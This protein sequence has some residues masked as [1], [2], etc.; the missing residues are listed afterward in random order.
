[1]SSATPHKVTSNSLLEVRHLTKSYTQHNLPAVDGVDLQVAHQEIIALLG[2]SGCGK[3]TLL[4]L[5]AGFETIDRGAILLEGR[6]MAHLP[7]EMR[8]IGMVFQ[9]FALFPHLTCAENVAFGLHKKPPKLR[10]KII[11]EVLELV[12][13]QDFRKRLPHQLSGGQQQ[14]LALARALA[15]DPTLILL[16][17]PLSNLDAQIRWQLRSELR[18]ILKTAGKSAILVTH[19]QEEA[20]HIADRVAV[21][22][23]GKIEQLDT[24]QGI[25]ERPQTAF[26]AEFVCQANN[27][28]AQRGENGW[29]TTIG[30][31]ALETPQDQ[32]EILV[33]P[34]SLQI[35][36]DPKGTT[37]IVDRLFLG[38]EVMYILKTQAQHTLV[39][40]SS[41]AKADLQVGATVAVTADPRQILLFQPSE[42]KPY[43]IRP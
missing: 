12:G 11:Q 39:A 29:E 26:V 23:R 4:R 3:T 43:P 21:M 18:R 10:Q 14:R 13:L 38:R 15:P 24:P 28:W 19:D 17:E 35:S 1:M 16:D 33:R 20:L 34:E 22:R 27:L 9:D 30:P 31:L 32:I 37:T 41:R 25:Y 7:P 42:P 40:R 6:S 8:G 2:P 5:I 36:P